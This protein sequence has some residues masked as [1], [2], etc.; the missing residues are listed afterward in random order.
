MNY[1][2]LFKWFHVHPE[3][4]FEET[5]TTEKI[6]EILFSQGIEILN[7]GLKT[8]LIAVVRGKYPGKSICLRADIDA[9]PIAE[10]TGL[11]YSS[12]AANAMHACGHDFHT[13]ATIAA[14]NI[15]QLERDKLKGT[16]YFAFEP[17]EEVFGG[18]KALIDTGLLNG[19]SEF[20]GFHV[21]P[22][23]GVGQIGIKAGGVMAAVDR[24]RIEVTGNGTHAATPHLGNNPIP[25]L[26]SLISSLQTFSASKL[27]PT[28]PHIIGFTEICGGTA[29]NIIPDTAFCEGTVRT[30][31]E[32]D[33]DKIH[34]AF[35]RIISYHGNLTESDC[36]LNWQS[37]APCIENDGEL[38]AL[39]LDAARKVGLE[40]VSVIPE[41]ISDD[42]S[43]LT[44]ENNAKGLYIRI[45]SGIGYSLH[46]PQFSVN[47]SAIEPTAEFLTELIKLTL[48]G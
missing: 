36:R 38:C 1:T 31:N 14:A 20:Y 32:N 48:K 43:L 45:G 34:T 39:A 22:S 33:R 11:T 10:Q 27:S 37:G 46:H 12:T 40:T 15:L 2:E 17:G 41:M 35:E 8:G 19:V 26:I 29:W 18:A 16:V 30:L 3:L 9:L 4:G 42:F 24:F 13:T 21:S 25:I 6:K 28:S 47:P 7:T 5:A 44:K 23:M